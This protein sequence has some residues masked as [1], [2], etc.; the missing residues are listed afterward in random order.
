MVFIS[1]KTGPANIGDPK[2]KFTVQYFDEQGNMVIRSGGTRAWRCNNP[3]NLHRGKYS[4]SKQRRA[5]GFAGDSEDEYAVYPDKETGH[6]AL[7]IMLRGSVYS[8]K[9]LHAAMKYYEPKKKDY[10]GIIV[11]RTGLDP[12]R[13]IKSLN[14]KEFE[15]FWKAIEFVEDWTEGEEDFIPRGIILGVHKKR[16]V[17]TEYLVCINKKSTW[18]SKQDAIKWTMEGKLHAILVHMKNGNHY[19]RPEHGQHS[20]VVVT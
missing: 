19:L 14:D 7:V 5:I 13:T 10:I 20:F 1:A 2:S 18:L 11:A 12:E 9:T 15:S 3:G 8:P 17:I 16:K 6:E 4:M